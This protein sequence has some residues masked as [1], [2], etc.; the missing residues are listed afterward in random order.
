M[1]QQTFPAGLRPRILVTQVR[2]DLSVVTWKQQAISVE[3]DGRVV[4]INQE[5]DLLTIIDCDSDLTLQVPEDAALKATEV[6][7]DVTIE[8]VRLAQL[9]EVGGDVSLK[10][11]SGDAGLE[12]IGE[13]IEITT[14]GGDLSV[15]NSPVLRVRHIVGS[16][17]TLKQ[18]GMVEIET[19]GGD[20]SIRAAET[21]LVST[22]GG[23]L[24]AEEVVAA[25][26]CGVVSGDAQVHA[27]PETEVM[28]GNVGGDLSVSRAESVLVGNLGGDCDLRD[29]RGDAEIGHTGGDLNINGVG[30]NLQ[31]GSVGGDASFKGLQG[32]IGAVKIG[33]DLYLQATFAPESMTR[34]QVGGDATIIMPDE[35]NLS[36]SARV[37]G[38]ISGR[39][40]IASRSG[41]MINLVYGNGAAHLD[42]NVGGDLALRGGGSPRSSSSSSGPGG[43][44]GWAGFGSE[45]SNLGRELSKLG[46]DL[47]HEIASAFSEA[48]WT[49][50]AGVADD[51]ARR[52]E[53]M[54][55]RSQQKSDEA[56]RRANEHASRIN[57]RLNDREWRMDPERLNRIREQARQAT[58]EGVTGAFEA[59]ERAVS[60]MGM[61]PRPVS[62]VSPVQPVSPV[63]P[64]AP[65]QPVSSLEET[66]SPVQNAE[67]AHIDIDQERE[68][69]LRMIAEG[70]VTPE[71]GDMLLEALGS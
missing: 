64:V 5:G 13:A 57:I 20:L 70:R 4:G 39:S 63:E 25:L 61:P 26:R 1:T 37:G 38:D 54:A 3:T 35:P 12:N 66:E 15:V 51:I 41:N 23:D 49:R 16:D 19:V 9:E 21:V 46:Q 53:E 10:D 58:N 32:N 68:A 2:G 22:V 14:L 30:G 8:G 67:A 42:L 36:I 65:V 27:Q 60:N 47:S 24:D 50:G 34:M 17:A 40:I 48:G 29:V 43:S 18:V 7:G 62:P 28:V 55:H 69:I 44:K 33:G 52:A 31:T 59:V 11:I 45:F 71:E 6:E 56:A